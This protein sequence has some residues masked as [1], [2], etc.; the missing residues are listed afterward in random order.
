MCS[1]RWSW[2]VKNKNCHKKKLKYGREKLIEGTIK[3][4]G[5][6]SVHIGEN[7]TNKETKRHIIIF[8]ISM[9][10]ILVCYFGM[11]GW[12]SREMEYSSNNEFV[13]TIDCAQIIDKYGVDRE[14]ILS[15]D[16]KA[17]CPGDVLVYFQNGSNSRYSYH[18]RIQVD[19]EYQQITMTVSPVLK[20]EN[21]EEAYLA[22][23]GEYGT[24]IIPTIRHISFEIK[25]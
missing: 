8:C 5:G 24:G 17:A 14:Y 23:Y 11:R 3:R 25:E 9:I 21:I 18:K 15:F 1:K 22:F 13:K 12:I 4:K 2:F 19:T 10:L 16:I 7:L 20:D 6:M